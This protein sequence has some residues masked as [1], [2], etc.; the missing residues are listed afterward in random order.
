[1]T[2][3]QI[4]GKILNLEAQLESLK[5]VLTRKPD[6]VIDEENWNKIRGEAKKIRKTLYRKSYGK[7]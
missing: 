1:M 6:F 7:R 4:K 2:Q 5:K 3:T